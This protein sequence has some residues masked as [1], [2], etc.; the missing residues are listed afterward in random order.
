MAPM[1]KYVL[2]RNGYAPADE[3]TSVIGTDDVA[4]IVRD[5]DGPVLMLAGG[6]LAAELAPLIDELFLLVGP[7]V[8]GRGR[9]LLDLAE[10]VPTRLLTAYAIPP[11][12]TIVRYA[13]AG[14][15]PSAR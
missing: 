6:A 15:F 2:S 11:S 4:R 8:L 5:A 12:C 13:V 3:R 9:P 1:R 7:I 10:P 14:E